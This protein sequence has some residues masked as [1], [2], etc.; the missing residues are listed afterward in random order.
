MSVGQREPRRRWPRLSK[1]G[2]WRRASPSARSSETPTPRARWIERLGD[3]PGGE[4]AILIGNEFLDCLPVDQAVWR[5]GAWRERRIGLQRRSPGVRRS[6][7]LP[8]A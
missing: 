3:L 1:S 4:P 7:A 8:G 2:W 6:R 5:A